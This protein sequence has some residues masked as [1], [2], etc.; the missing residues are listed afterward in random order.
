MERDPL[1]SL[2]YRVD[3]G[4]PRKEN[5]EEMVSVSVSFDKI[6]KILKWI[7]ERIKWTKY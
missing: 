5:K 4:P 1:D 2:D 3:E 7:K 6:G